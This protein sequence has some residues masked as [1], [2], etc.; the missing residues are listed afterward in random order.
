LP[1]QTVTVAG[2]ERFPNKEKWKS[3]IAASQAITLLLYP[4]P[5]WL[6]PSPVI[7]RRRFRPGLRRQCC[8]LASLDPKM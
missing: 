2:G 6:E 3:V 1:A 5:R 4:P 8:Y 7:L